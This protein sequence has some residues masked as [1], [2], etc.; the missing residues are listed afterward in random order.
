MCV[1]GQHHASRLTHN[2]RKVEKTPVKTSIIAT[3]EARKA[4]L[5]SADSAAS[6]QNSNLQG[7]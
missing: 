3:A 2:V 7:R 1:T 6:R 5:R 4:R